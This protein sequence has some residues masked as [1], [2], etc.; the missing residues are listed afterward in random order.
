MMARQRSRMK[1]LRDGDANTKL[2]H[3]FANG[4]RL[5]NFICPLQVGNELVTE[6]GRKEDCFFQFYSETL[7]AIH[8]RDSSIDLNRLDLPHLDLHEFDA[9][10]TEDEVWGVIKEL[11]PDRAPGP[12][13]YTGTF[14]QLA[15]T[16]IKNDIMA[17]FLKL[18]VG[19]GRGF[20]KLNRALIMLIPKK[21]NAQELGDYRPIS[22]GK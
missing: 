3:A 6:Q 22:F 2:F 16:L 8:T 20:G 5:K 21:S 12:D 9:I 18:F 19:D 11:P 4:R 14:Y 1:W 7:G 10:F 17:I 15:W 13:G